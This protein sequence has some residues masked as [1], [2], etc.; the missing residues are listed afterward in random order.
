MRTDHVLA[1]S[2]A[3]EAF[4]EATQ[5]YLA[6]HDAERKRAEKALHFAS[7]IAAPDVVLVRSDSD[8]PD[9]LKLAMERVIAAEQMEA[10][11]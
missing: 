9:S 1:Y 5:T 7:L 2:R 6:E 11:E 10:A 4:R 3:A 8:E